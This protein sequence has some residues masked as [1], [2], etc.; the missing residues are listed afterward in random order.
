MDTL[1]KE[2][3]SRS[4][5]HWNNGTKRKCLCVDETAIID[6]K[7][8]RYESIIKPIKN[9]DELASLTLNDAVKKINEVIER[10]NE[11]QKTTLT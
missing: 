2:C 5:K 11:I 7:C 1:K 9:M 3:M 4:C 8:N 6:G 10:V